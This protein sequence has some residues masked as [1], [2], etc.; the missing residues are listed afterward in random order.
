MAVCQTVFGW[1]GVW[2]GGGEA[3]KQA[4]GTV[5]GPMMRA[6]ARQW[7]YHSLRCTSSTSTTAVPLTALHMP[8]LPPAVTAVPLSALNNTPFSPAEPTIFQDCQSGSL[9]IVCNLIFG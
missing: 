3:E 4:G 5:G 9:D 7:Q 8:V 6:S 1:M 2:V